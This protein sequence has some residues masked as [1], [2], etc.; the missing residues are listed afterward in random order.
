M[1]MQIDFE[2]RDEYLLLTGLETD[3]HIKTIVTYSNFRA[4]A[5]PTYSLSRGLGLFT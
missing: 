1:S 3:V 4:E 5:N 2:V